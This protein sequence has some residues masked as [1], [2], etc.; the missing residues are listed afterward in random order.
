MYAIK[1]VAFVILNWYYDIRTLVK[2]LL[3]YLT[4]H[5]LHELHIA[6]QVRVCLQAVVRF[7]EV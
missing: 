7:V 1:S 4:T 5:F 6:F 3:M 2:L